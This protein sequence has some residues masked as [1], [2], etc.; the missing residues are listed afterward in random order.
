MIAQSTIDR[1]LD[2]ANI[3][4]VVSD[5]VTLRRAGASY[6]GLCPFHDDTTP[7]FSVSPAK[8]ICKCFACGKGGDPVHFIM[9][10]EQISFYEAIK[11]LGKKFGIEVEDKQ[12]TVEQRRAESERESMYAVNEWASEYFHSTMMNTDEGKAYGLAYFRS[13]GFR[14]DIIEKFRLGVCLD[15]S[16]AM[17]AEALKKGY[18]EAFLTKTGLSFATAEKKLKDKYHGRVM[19]PWFGISGKITGFGGRVLDART[20]GVNQK[21]INSPESEIY[22]KRKELY[23]LFQA[24]QAIKKE[25]RVYMVEGYTDVISMHQCGIENVVANSGTAL[26]PEQV[27]LLLR[28][29]KNVTL[30]YDG[31]PAGIKAALKGTDMFLSAGMNVNILLL[32]DGDDPDSFARK[33]NATEFKEYVETHQK[34]FITFKTEILLGEAGNDPQK[35]KA[36]IDSI[37]ESIAE[38]PEEMF[39]S[40]YIHQCSEMTNVQEEILTREVARRR[41]QNWEE[42]KKREERHILSETQ[43]PQSESSTSL[44]AEGSDETN[45][46]A[47]TFTAPSEATNNQTTKTETP[48]PSPTPT[49]NTFGVSSIPSTET[50]FIGLERLIMRMIVRYGTAKFKDVDEDGTEIDISVIE[51]VK[52][53]MEV[54]DLQFRYPLYRDMLDL[55]VNLVHSSPEIS[56]S[57]LSRQ[58]VSNPRIDIS[59]EATDLMSDRYQLS[60]EGTNAYCD[61]ETR[62]DEYITHLLLDYKFAIVV[63]AINQIKRQLADPTVLSDAARCYE[64]LKQQITLNNTKNQLAKKL[65]DR[66]IG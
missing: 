5:Y 59:C 30:L 54:D 57:T 41:K 9:E 43:N 46:T 37:V 55:A 12:L 66:V 36:L 13:R 56:G 21:Y 58:F 51:F 27:R 47:T 40:V 25:D 48:Q 15:K 32:P 34:D 17:S 65:G 29:T 35:K 31:D 42:K 19:F 16:D 11:V 26:T 45:Q 18:N 22:S 64:L 23:G 4:D 33:H 8:N 38:I 28:F 62:P 50:K 20:K 6:R 60:K 39:R 53:E 3:T 49:N 7:S 10:I 1:V 24:K 14:D 2:A 63:D 44:R 52:Q 61:E